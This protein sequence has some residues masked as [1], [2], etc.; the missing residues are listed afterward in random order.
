MRI[1]G[2]SSSPRHANTEL[3]VKQALRVCR[4]ELGFETVLVSFVHKKIRACVGCLGCERK[5]SYCILKDDWRE[6]VDHLID[7]VPDGLIIGSPVYAFN[8]N[9]TLRAFMERCSSLMKRKWNP[10]FPYP[11]PD[12]SRTISGAISVGAD[13]HGGQEQAI[14]TIVQW[15]LTCGFPVVSSDYI[16]APAWQRIPDKDGVEQDEL[17]LS[18]AGNLARRIGGLARLVAS[19]QP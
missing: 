16:G 4:E 10:D 6:L 12:W 3:L 1:V 18:G 13:R 9:A 14:T 11:V 17:G 7:P 8:V 19:K 2:I 15:L 5:G